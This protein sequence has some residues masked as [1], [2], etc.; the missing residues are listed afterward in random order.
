MS[1]NQIIDEGAVIG[2]KP[3]LEYTKK[4]KSDV[5]AKGV[6]NS[7]SN[8]VNYSDTLTGF[9]NNLPSTALSNIDYVT[10]NMKLLIDRLALSFNN[11]SWDQYGEISSLLT[12]LES[13]NKE[14]I[15]NFINYHKDKIT[16]SI[17]PEL[18]G[19]V[20][21]TKHK[22]KV[23]SDILKELYYG[24]SSLTTDEVKEIDNA[25]LKKLQS[26]EGSGD[27]AKINYLAL[28][29]DSMLNRSVNMCAFSLNKQAID[30]ANV[31]IASDNSS[32]SLSKADFIQKMFDEIN[33]ELNN[34]KNYYNEQQ[35]V[36]IME[37]TLYNYYNKRQEIINLYDLF[38]ENKESIFIGSK[39]QSYSEQVDESITN[40]NK[41]FAGNK[42]FLSEMVKLEREK[43]LLMNI[44]ATINYKSEI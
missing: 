17:V 43:H 42:H 1:R 4:G 30:I 27:K 34:K 25:Y 20:Y 12:A 15:D 39:I 28:S 29:H 41:V 9:T 11:G 3:T 6:N 40:I 18:V 38:N 2:Y 44:Y 21:D 5:N 32:A 8:K 37:K 10:E 33:D 19:L 24:Q 22:L 23:L 13:N 31:I 14:Y 7:P 16:G 36:E 26:Y 35:N